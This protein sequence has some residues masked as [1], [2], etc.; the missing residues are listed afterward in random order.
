MRRHHRRIAFVGGIAVTGQERSDNV[1]GRRQLR[2][3]RDH[4]RIDP[5]AQS[6]DE[7]ARP[8][9]GELTAH[10]SGDSF[11]ARHSRTL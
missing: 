7:T 3:A 9:G 2:K 6:D 4:R 8:G 5:A 1:A 11:G 10:P